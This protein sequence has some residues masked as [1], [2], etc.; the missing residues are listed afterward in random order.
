MQG[1]KLQNIQRRGKYIRD[2][3]MFTQLLDDLLINNTSIS[4]GETVSKFTKRM[5]I[6]TE[7]ES[8]YGR[9]IDLIVKSKKAEEQY[10]LSSNEF[11]QSNAAID[12]SMLVFLMT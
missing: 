9:R 7:D 8:D 1:E 10:N 12:I 2:V 4:D 5:K 3:R 6:V 11:K